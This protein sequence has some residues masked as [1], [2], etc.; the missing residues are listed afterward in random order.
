M[1]YFKICYIT[2]TFLYYKRCGGKISINSLKF[3]NLL[4]HPIIILLSKVITVVSLSLSH[5]NLTS[6]LIQ[7]RPLRNLLYYPRN[8]RELL[9]PV[10]KSS[11]SISTSKLQEKW[12]AWEVRGRA[13]SGDNIR[14]W[15]ESVRKLDVETSLEKWLSL[16]VPPAVSSMIYRCGWRRGRPDGSQSQSG[17]TYRTQWKRETFAIRAPLTTLISILVFTRNFT[18]KCTLLHPTKGEKRSI[19]KQIKRDDSFYKYVYVR[20]NNR[21][22]N[23]WGM[24]YVC[25]FL[26]NVYTTHR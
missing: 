15:R 19:C 16:L 14:A 2:K 18:C 1:I 11:A 6:H 26:T 12:E 10:V 25:H 9:P 24:T 21:Y 13:T 20:Q 3:L 8:P 23:A 5:A 4:Q 22:I 7:G 17:I